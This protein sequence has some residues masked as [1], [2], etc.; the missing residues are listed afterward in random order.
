MANNKKYTYDKLAEV[1]S[2]GIDIALYPQIRG[3]I[4]DRMKEIF[5]NDIDLSTASA[6]G[7]YINMESLIFNNM[8]GLISYLFNNLNPNTASGKYLD[9][10]A[11]LSNVKR[12]GPTHSTAVVLVKYVGA[13]NNYTPEIIVAQDRN[14]V[15]WTWRNPIG[16]NGFVYSFSAG[17]DPVYLTFTCNNLGAVEAYKGTADAINWSST[18][19]LNTNG[20][21]YLE[22][23]TEFK[24]YQYNDAVVGSMSESDTALRNRRAKY[25]GGNSQTTQ[26]GLETDLYN[27]AAVEDV[28]VFNNTTGIRRDLVDN[29]E[30]L[31]HDVYIAIRYKEN[32]DLPKTRTAISQIIYNNLT[33]GV[34]TSD[35]LGNGGVTPI[36][37]GSM[38]YETIEYVSGYSTNVYWK[39]CSPVKPGIQIV[40][41]TVS[42][43]IPGTDP[44]QHST[45]EQSIVAS[46]INYF[47][48]LQIGTEIT[49]AD[50]QISMMSGDLKPNGTN[51]F[52]TTSCEINGD[53]EP[54]KAPITYFKYDE[55][56]FVFDY[57]GINPVLNIN[58]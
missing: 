27:Y 22:L 50:V 39:E 20:S 4:A 32:I 55:S 9:V 46:M 13:T 5:G 7:Q 57:S 6:D 26:V 44:N 37:G 19:F 48:N 30:I 18:T 17:D 16:V 53:T 54:Y 12:K 47:N 41:K 40:F 23:T 14:G 15:E 58:N 51:S 56:D 21:I 24:L 25:I 36:T 52:I 45:S 1:N 42:G 29:A 43:Y 8:Y 3:A 34:N 2:N 49:P 33:A 31:N 35:G 38:H 28:F 10:L 11:S